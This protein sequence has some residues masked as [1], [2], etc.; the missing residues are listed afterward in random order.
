MF[1]S[2]DTQRRIFEVCHVNT[3]PL[4]FNVFI[5]YRTNYTADTS[6][7]FPELMNGEDGAVIDRHWKISNVVRRDIKIVC[8]EIHTI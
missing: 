6:V 2:V 5:D 1:E 3:Q 7:V 4:N 8:F